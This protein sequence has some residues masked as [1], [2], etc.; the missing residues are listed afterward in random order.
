MA[1]TGVNVKALESLPEL[2]MVDDFYN[3]MYDLCTGT[4]TTMEYCKLHNMT[5]HEIVEA[6][7]ILSRIS[8]M[9]E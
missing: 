5:N 2:Q 9:V 7:F 8:L 3:Q 1:G 4:Q 6:L